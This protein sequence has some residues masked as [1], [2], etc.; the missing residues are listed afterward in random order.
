M[1]RFELLKESL[2]GLS[3]VAVL[4]NGANPAKVADWSVT[5]FGVGALDRHVCG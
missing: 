3:R 5:H 2:P 1:K 4:W